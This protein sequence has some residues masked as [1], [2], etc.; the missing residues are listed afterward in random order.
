MSGL[1][2]MVYLTKTLHHTEADDVMMPQYFLRNWPFVTELY[3]PQADFLNKS[4]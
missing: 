1:D 3:C 2:G 4:T